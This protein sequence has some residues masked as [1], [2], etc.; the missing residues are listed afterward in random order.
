M[1]AGRVSESFLRVGKIAFLLA[2][3]GLFFTFLFDAE[4]RGEAYHL[5]AG[6]PFLAPLLFV[7]LQMLFSSLALPCSPLTVSAGMLWGLREGMVYSILATMCASTWT[8][9][10]GRY[11]L[12]NRL[13]SLRKSKWYLVMLEMIAKHDWKASLF[14]YINPVFPSSSLGFAFGVSAIS[15]N[16]FLLGAFLGTLPLQLA[17]VAIGE[18][19]DGRLGGIL[20]GG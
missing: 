16:S 18:I 3:V 20:Q 9:L 7:M 13:T 5:L 10:L 15:M 8:F 19:A 11:L 4:I 14:V 17:M 6:H 1:I 2:W 12:R